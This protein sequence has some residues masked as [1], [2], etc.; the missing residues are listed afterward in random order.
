MKVMFDLMNEARL[1]VGLQGLGSATTA[2]EH[3]VEYAKQRLQ[4]AGSGR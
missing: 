1:E 3:A 2:Y 4:G